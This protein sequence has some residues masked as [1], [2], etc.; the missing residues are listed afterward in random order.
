MN[1]LLVSVSFLRILAAAAL[2]LAMVNDASALPSFARQTGERCAACHVGGDWPQLTPWGRFFKLSGYTVGE[3]FVSKKGLN[4]SPIGVFGQAGVT[5]AKEPNNSLG[6]PVI[7]PDGS[8]QGEQVVGYVG[9]KLADFAGVFYEYELNNNYPSWTS[10]T[11][12]TDIRAVHFFNPGNNELLIGLNSN[13]GPGNQDV[14]NTVPAWS[15]PFYASPIA[16]GP[17][18]STMLATLGNQ[19]GSFGIYGLWNRTLYGEVSMY[20]AGNG[21][22][23]WMTQ[24]TSFNSP[25]GANYADGYNPYWRAWWNYA[26]GPH[27]LMLGTYGMVSHVYPDPTS[28]TGPT[29]KFVDYYF[30]TQYQYLQDLHKFTLRG[31]FYTENQT[32]SGSYPQGLSSTPTGSLNGLSV[33]GTYAYRDTWTFSAAYYESNGTNNAALYA[34]SGPNGNQLTASPNTSGYYFQVNYLPIQNLKLQLQYSGFLRFNGLTSNIDGLGRSPSDNNTLWLNL[35]L[36][37]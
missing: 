11:G 15:Y 5:W 20:R 12:V 22:F 37:I 36:A 13:N 33:S 35:F 30:D 29:D 16:P 3:M 10:A 23:R 34:V 31:Y 26:W 14:W 24:G 32:W 18:A 19:V 1:K 4:H 17:P 25:G 7:T 8:F 21:P 6:Q 2:L 27:N 28:Q 9:T